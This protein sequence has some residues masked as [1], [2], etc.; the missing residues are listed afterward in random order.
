RKLPV[1]CDI[2]DLGAVL[3]RAARVARVICSQKSEKSGGG[4]TPEDP[5]PP[6]FNSPA[7]ATHVSNNSLEWAKC[8][9]FPAQEARFAR[10]DRAGLFFMKPCKVS[11]DFSCFQGLCFRKKTSRKTDNETRR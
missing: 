6:R 1:R 4:K 7:S 9:N 8:E 5:G 2:F 3:R 11:S 10:S